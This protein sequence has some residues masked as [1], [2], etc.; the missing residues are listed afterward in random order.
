MF[1]SNDE[2]RTPKTFFKNLDKHVGGFDVDL[3]A[4]RG[5]NLVKKYYTMHDSCLEHDWKG[6]CFCNPPY[7]NIE[8]FLKHAIGEVYGFGLEVWFLIPSNFEQYYH[9]LIFDM[10]EFVEAIYFIKGRISF[11]DN[12]NKTVGSPRFNNILVH[13]KFGYDPIKFYT[14]DRDFTNIQKVS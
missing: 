7:S 12:N 2:W 5:N 14:V 8:P 6:K 1:V 11:L 13:Y 4:Y 3:C 10:K 9:D